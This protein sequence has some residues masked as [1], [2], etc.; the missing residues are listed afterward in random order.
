MMGHIHMN[1]TNSNNIVVMQALHY[2]DAIAM[3]GHSLDYLRNPESQPLR[4][5]KTEPCDYSTGLFWPRLAIW[6]VAPP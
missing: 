5:L 4:A 6:I 3:I 1:Q 2:I